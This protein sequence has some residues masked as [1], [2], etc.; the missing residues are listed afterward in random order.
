ME[1]HRPK[2][3]H[4]LREFLK[5]YA[6]IVLGV[7]TALAGEQLVEWNHWRHEVAE[8]ELALRQE[9]GHDLMAVEYRVSQ[10][11]C[12]KRRLDDLRRWRGSWLAGAGRPLTGYMSAPTTVSLYTDSWEVAESGQVAAHIPLERRMQYAKI[13]ATVRVLRTTS[14]QARQGWQSLQDFEDA[15]SLD[16]HDLMRL[17]GLVNY[18]NFYEENLATT[19]LPM[20]RERSSALGVNAEHHDPNTPVLRQSREAL[21]KSIFPA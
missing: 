18:L 11:D 20:L 6:I 9:L 12:A 19:N 4:G 3:W 13:Y 21:C 10:A 16:V 1:I 8:T 7:L 14:E 5:E 15:P 2:P 17:R